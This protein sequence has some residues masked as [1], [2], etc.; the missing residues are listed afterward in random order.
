MTPSIP[1]TYLQRHPNVEMLLDQAATAGSDP[2]ATS[3]AGWSCE[4]GCS[5]HSPSSDLA[6]GKDE[7]G[8]P[9]ADDSDYN[10]EG[11]QDLLAEYGSAYEN[12]P[13]RV[14]TSAEHDCRLAC[15]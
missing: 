8:D 9:E 4:V 14:S 15:G 6:V 5:D 12:Q 2:H 13:D 3:M 11:Q 1:A 7:Q 10:E